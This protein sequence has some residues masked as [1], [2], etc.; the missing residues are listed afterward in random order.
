MK[1]LVLAAMVAALL[2][3]QAQAQP[4]QT[5]QSGQVCLDTSRIERT[6]VPDANTILFHMNDRKIWK[7]TLKGGCPTLKTNGFTYEPSPP[8]QICANMQIIRVIHTGS[9]CTIGPIERYTPPAK[10]TAG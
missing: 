4:A 3:A 5:S 8:H 7:A 6:S 1:T 10:G 2:G 9:V